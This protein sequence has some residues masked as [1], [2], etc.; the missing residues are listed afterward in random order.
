MRRRGWAK[1]NHDRAI[2]MEWFKFVLWYLLIAV[3]NIKLFSPPACH[4]M[5]KDETRDERT[6]GNISGE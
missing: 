2:T 1:Q 5:T 3:V 4:I 6:V